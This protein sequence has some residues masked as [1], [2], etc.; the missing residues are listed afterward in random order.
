ML[1]KS[2]FAFLALFALNLIGCGGGTSTGGSTAPTPPAPDFSITASPQSLTIGLGGSQTCTVAI[3]AINGFGGSVGVT[4]SGLPTGVIA[5]PSTFTVASGSPQQVTISV[6]ATTVPATT[7]I[8]FQGTATGLSH[9]VKVALDLIPQASGSHAPIRSRYLRTDSYYNPNSL[10]YAPP[11]FTVY[12]PVHK[13]FYV[14]NPFLNE[15]D[16]FDAMQEIEIAQISV[17]YAWGIDILPLTNTL[18]AATLLGDIYQISTQTNLVTTRFP[19]ASIGPSGYVATEAFVLADGRLALLGSQSGLSVDGAPSAAVWDPVTNTLDLGAPTSSPLQTPSICPGIQNIGAFAVSG[20]R[21]RVLAASIDEGGGGEPV[22]SYDPATQTATMGVFPPTTFVREIIPTPDGTRFFLTSNLNGVA[23]FDAKTVQL[24]GQITQPAPN[25]TL[26]NAPSGAVMSLDGKTLYL[27]DQSSGAVAAYNTTTFTQTGWVPSFRISDLQSGPVIAAIDDTGLIVGPTGHGVDFLD[28]SQSVSAQPAVI[29]MTSASPPTGTVSGG[30]VIS[31]VAGANL[32]NPPPLKEIYVG[33]SAGTNASYSAPSAGQESQ[34]Q[35]TTPPASTPG[36]ADLTVLL[37]GGGLGIAPEGFSYGP[38][39]LEVTANAATAEGGQLGS[40]V[41]Y[42]FGQTSDAVQVSVGGHPSQV[43]TLSTTAPISPYPFPVEGLQFTVPPGTAGSAVDVTVTTGSGSTIAHNA[44]HYTAAVSSYAGAPTLQSGIYDPKRDL[45]YFA[46]RAEIQVFSKTSGRWL[47]PMT[48]PGVTAKTQLLAISESPDEAM[49]AVSDYGGQQIYVL[50]PDTPGST[51]SYPMPLDYFNTSSL[52]PT[53][54]AITDSGIV[55]FSTADIAGTGTPAFH[56]LD[57][58]TSTI[59]DLGNFQS[60]IP[61]YPLVRVLL[62]PDGSRVYSSIEGTSFWL[63]TTNDQ[64]HY[65]N[66][67]SS[68]SGWIPDLAI[69]GD[70]STVA[71]N[72]F[73]ANPSLNAEMAPE[74]V[75]W[76]TW[77]PIAT[78]GQK[79]NQDGSMLL[80]PLTDGIEMI[81]RNTGRLLYRIQTP[82]TTAN[83]YDSFFLAGGSDVLGVITT[84]GI[85]FVDLS[86]LPIPA[87]DA[88]P[89]PHVAGSRESLSPNLQDA[90][91]SKLC[92]PGSVPNGQLCTKPRLKRMN[93]PKAAVVPHW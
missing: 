82:F 15:I 17:P 29:Q 77:L 2:G 87:N 28:A 53:G 81:A 16:V 79:L 65:S 44:F 54:V 68:G 19:S 37:S 57:T 23:V 8:T 50:D 22:C 85:A 43:V 47:A 32:T 88:L 93:D 59:T 78:T 42:G 76:E 24:L 39:I 21:T 9:S 41:G 3:S 27:V 83:A 13:Q 84:S 14:S 92:S 45:Y 25:S 90:V 33:T 56:K 70:G 67:T 86:T 40:I 38:T 12:D 35:V 55:Y 5:T 49:I 46:D 66:A 18:Y 71:V 64:I 91:A 51:K 48:L 52:A 74:Y 31:S 89:F 7:T 30:T 1:R 80:Q 34:V 72:A 20:D 10:E 6:A 4:V 36:A 58:S 69:S 61:S 60:G 11:H 26:P 63:D 62:S 75:D 73:F